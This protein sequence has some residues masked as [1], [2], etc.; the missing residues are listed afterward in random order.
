[1]A[2]VTDD[3]RPSAY[4]IEA[5]AGREFARNIPVTGGVLTSPVLTMKTSGGDAF[6]RDPGV[7]V[8]SMTTADTLRLVWSAADMA[9]LNDT[10]RSKT[11][12]IDVTGSV[13][14]NSPQSVIGGTLTVHPTTHTRNIPQTS[15]TLS[16]NN[17][18]TLELALTVPAPGVPIDGGAPDE[19]YGGTTGIDGGLY[20]DTF[21]D[22]TYDGGSI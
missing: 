19:A 18:P 21:T 9:A 20:S 14:G 13:D 11:Y 6:T 5:V 7:G 17:G 12:R 2:R 4:A 8:A 16:L 1:M 10:T 3:V 22:T 15:V